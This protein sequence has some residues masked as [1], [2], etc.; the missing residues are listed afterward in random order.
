MNDFWAFL[1]IHTSNCQKTVPSRISHS[2]TRPKFV[3][4]TVWDPDPDSTIDIQNPNDPQY[5]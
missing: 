1:H 5:A 3:W 4:G 2:C